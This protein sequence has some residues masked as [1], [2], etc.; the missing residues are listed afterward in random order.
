[1]FVE[2][3]T[4]YI[5]FDTETTGLRPYHGDKIF[6][7]SLGFL[8][9]L[10]NFK[11]VFHS[12]DRLPSFRELFEDPSKIWFIQNAKFDMA[13]LAQHGIEIKG[14]IHC[15]KAIGLVE[16]NSH[17]GYSLAEQG[18]RLGIKKDDTVE[19]YIREH[20]LTEKRMAAT[21]SY[22]HK[23]FDRVPIELIGP[24]CEQDTVVCGN[25]GINQCKTIEK[26]PSL[27]RVFENEKR[28]TQTLFN[29]ER[30]G[31]RVD[32]DYSRK[33]HDYERGR[34]E[35]A[36]GEFSA[37][38]GKPFQSSP[39]LFAEI[40]G[41]FREQWS[42]TDKGNPSFD[43]DSLKKFKSPVAKAILDYRDAKS[44]RDFYAGFLY[45][46]DAQG[47][48][49]PNYNQSGTVHGRMSSSEPNFQNLTSEEGDE[50]NEFTVR[51]AIIP[52]EG[53]I[54]GVIDQ[55]AVEY[56]LMFDVASD[57]QG[58]ASEITRKIIDG[59]DPHQAT[60]DVVTASGFE[61][62][63][64]RAKN[65]NFAFLYGSG[66]KTLAETIGVPVQEA[67]R[68]R[69]AMAQGAPEV[70]R[71]IDSIIRTARSRGY[72]FNW[73][74]RRCYFPDPRFAYRAPNYLIAGGAADVMKVGMNRIDDFLKDKQ[75]R[76]VMN[77]HDELIFEIHETEPEVL[78]QCQE[79][80][81][82]VYPS[83]YIPL[84]CSSYTSRKS[85]A[86]LS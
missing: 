75:S 82:N 49:H 54:L 47:R 26:T 16:Y 44:K 56:R 65:G 63:R 53:F 86:D 17:P 37:L 80:L 25:L 22:T 62:S 15:T 9:D 8:T 52:T 84:L 1:M 11:T 6:C 57:L 55:K 33:A 45:Y 48:V 41:E 68:L 20:K 23:F 24:Y 19:K 72:I 39:K 76:L 21:R 71:L 32:T 69:R 27:Q 81:E 34:M 42:Y 85:L 29:M 18:E 31:V 78:K 70:V 59:H 51:R 13:F 38:V 7:F 73:L 35:A 50:N 28:L 36:I 60:A 83:K 46:A 4:K 64:S 12:V 10:G 43:S 74:G 30:R 3:S 5:A 66:D 79:I 2:H 40:F 58:Y 61:L 77:V 67:A 14:Q